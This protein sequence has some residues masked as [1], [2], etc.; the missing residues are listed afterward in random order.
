MLWAHKTP[1]IPLVASRSHKT[2]LAKRSFFTISAVMNNAG[3][4]TT[5]IKQPALLRIYIGIG[6]YVDLKLLL[7]DYQKFAEIRAHGTQIVKFRSEEIS[8]LPVSDQKLINTYWGQSVHAILFIEDISRSTHSSNRIAFSEGLYQKI[9]YDRL[10]AEAST[11]FH[12]QT[13]P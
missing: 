6:N 4:A 2:L 10:A 5:S 3:N 13:K 9:I 12:F 1:G 11:K 8:T 7:Q